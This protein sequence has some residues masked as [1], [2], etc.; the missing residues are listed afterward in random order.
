MTNINVITITLCIIR[1]P[2]HRCTST[3]SHRTK[4]I[5][6]HDY[7]SCVCVLCNIRGG[8]VEEQY[9]P[10]AYLV[11]V[12]GLVLSPSVSRSLS[13]SVHECKQISGDRDDTVNEAGYLSN[14]HYKAQYNRCC[15]KGLT[16]ES[17][18][19]RFLLMDETGLRMDLRIDNVLGEKIIVLVVFSAGGIEVVYS[20]RIPSQF[21]VV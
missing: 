14:M 8:F 20:F 3:N 12:K 10:H 1:T 17:F 9:T 5:Q 21:F 15:G 4:H 2:M 7:G 6:T 11:I 18:Y 19:K 16:E 13:Q